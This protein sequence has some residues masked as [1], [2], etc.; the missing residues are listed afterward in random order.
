ML[1]H[2]CAL[3]DLVGTEGL[4]TG[5]VGGGVVRWRERVSGQS[6]V[7]VAVVHSW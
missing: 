1:P 6:E 2:A 7:H 3:A 5:N 4:P